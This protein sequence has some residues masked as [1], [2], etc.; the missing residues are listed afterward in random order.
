M[1]INYNASINNSGL[2]L[3]YDFAN[4]KSYQENLLTYSSTFDNAIWTKASTSVTPNVTVAPDGT[5]TAYKLYNA[6]ATGNLYAYNAVFV[7]V[8]GQV[9]TT[10]IYVKAAEWSRFCIET[11]IGG[12]DT[13]A[14]FDLAAGTVLFNSSGTI[15][16]VGNGWYRCSVTA[17]AATAT[18]AGGIVLHALPPTVNTATVTITGDGVSGCYIWGAQLNRGST[19]APYVQTTS[20][21]TITLNDMSPSS[22]SANIVPVGNAVSGG[23][24]TAV[25]S[26]VFTFNGNP[27]YIQ[28]TSN[29]TLTN[30][31]TLEVWCQP[32]YTN[33]TPY[34]VQNTSWPAGREQCYRIQIQ[35]TGWTFVVATANNAWFTAGTNVSSGNPVI[36]WN[37]LVGV[38]DGARVLLYQNGIFLANGTPV[39]GAL[40]APGTTFNLANPTQ[41]GDNSIAYFK[42]NIGMVKVYNVGLTADQVAQNFQAHRGRYGI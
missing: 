41:S 10:S 37:Q 29:P 34:T 17:P 13:A 2:V 15:T 5:Q 8:I 36:G 35:P 30:A 40:A 12:N 23:T 38:Y 39:S 32:D 16:P 20:A 28:P 7:P 3:Y 25:N 21:L 18:T 4:T 19:P 14:W 9:Y 22:N 11:L 31:V 26:G 24:Y 1:S 6:V 42:G 27:Q 33:Q